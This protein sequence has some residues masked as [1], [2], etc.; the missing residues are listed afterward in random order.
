MLV[1]QQADGT[2]DLAAAH[3]LD[4]IFA[5]VGAH[6]QSNLRK[7]APHLVQRRRQDHLAKTM[8]HAKLQ[9]SGWIG[10]F[11]R[12]GHQLRNRCKDLA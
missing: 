11:L 7:R 10:H 3:L 8:S 12:A 2:I 1:R 6:L 9:I 5:P 4:Q